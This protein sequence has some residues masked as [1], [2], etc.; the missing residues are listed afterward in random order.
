MP[1]IRFP[2]RCG[3]PAEWKGQQD[4]MVRQVILESCRSRQELRRESIPGGIDLSAR[5]DWAS[6]ALRRLLISNV[7]PTPHRGHGQAASSPLARIVNEPE[8]YIEQRSI[9]G[10][11]ARLCH[12]ADGGLHQ[13]QFLLG[14]VSMQTTERYSIRPG[15]LRRT[16]PALR[17]QMSRAAATALRRPSSAS[18]P[19]GCL[20]A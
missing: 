5:R 17:C 20:P 2:T 3:N 13:I 8:E 12:F 4:S 15:R 6:S 9:Q 16:Y 10:P 11:G 18:A 19:S 7:C 14:H 1:E